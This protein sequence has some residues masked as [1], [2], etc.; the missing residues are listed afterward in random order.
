MVLD[1]TLTTEF[2]IKSHCSVYERKRQ[3]SVWA[4]V[5]DVPVNTQLCEI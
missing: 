1:L 5:P 4:S 2:E 3:C